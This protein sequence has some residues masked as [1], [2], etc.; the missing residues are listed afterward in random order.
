MFPLERIPVFAEAR[1]A[2]SARFSRFADDDGLARKRAVQ[3]A[4]LVGATVGV[5]VLFRGVAQYMLPIF[6]AGFLPGPAVQAR[7]L[8]LLR[9]SARR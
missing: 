4:T 5:C 6:I 2:L 7:N 1:D 3:F 9:R 8:W